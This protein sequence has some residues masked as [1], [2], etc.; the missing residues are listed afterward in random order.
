M[1]LNSRRRLT[2]FLNSKEEMEK[3]KQQQLKVLKEHE[4]ERTEMLQKLSEEIIR[5]NNLT[6]K[7]KIFNVWMK[8]SAKRFQLL[9]KAKVRRRLLLLQ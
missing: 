3:I 7:S 4:K 1:I 9:L 6:L 2:K 8:K 5:N